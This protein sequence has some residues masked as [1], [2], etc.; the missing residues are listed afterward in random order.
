VT[1]TLG[2]KSMTSLLLTSSSRARSLMRT[3]SI[4]ACVL[5]N[6]PS[7]LHLNLTVSVF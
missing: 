7:S 1:P 4:P 2:R 3:F 6:S 5:P